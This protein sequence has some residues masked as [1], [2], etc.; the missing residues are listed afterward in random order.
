MNA[1]YLPGFF[2]SF[3]RLR[4]EY[5]GKEKLGGRLKR[6]ESLSGLVVPEDELGDRRREL[7]REFSQGGGI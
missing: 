1:I 6:L 2:K 3:I 4:K 5:K 7:V